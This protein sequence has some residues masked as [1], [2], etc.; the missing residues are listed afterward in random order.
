MTEVGKG[1][2]DLTVALPISA[3]QLRY[4]YQQPADQEP[5]K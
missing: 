2:R 1:D 3:F 4:P 5:P